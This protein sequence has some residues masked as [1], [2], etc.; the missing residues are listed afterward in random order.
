VHSVSGLNDPF[1]LLLLLCLY[2]GDQA[3]AMRTRDDCANAL[4]EA[5]KKRPNSR[6]L[7]FA[8]LQN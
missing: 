2:A 4:T 6:P 3:S 1:T 5:A 7:R 8:D